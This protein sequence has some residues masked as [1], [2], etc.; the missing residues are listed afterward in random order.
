MYLAESKWV[1]VSG[2]Y[3]LKYSIFPRAAADGLLEQNISVT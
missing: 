3:R 1:F 2:A